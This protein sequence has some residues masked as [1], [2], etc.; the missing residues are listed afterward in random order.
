MGRAAEMNLRN[1][2]KSRGPL[3]DFSLQRRCQ[4]KLCSKDYGISE[5]SNYFTW[6]GK[7]KGV[8]CL[9]KVKVALKYFFC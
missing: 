9:S 2:Q 4:T 6:H 7:L 8:G 3:Q 1:K 5:E